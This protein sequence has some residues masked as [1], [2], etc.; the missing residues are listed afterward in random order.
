MKEC[1]NACNEQNRWENRR[2]VNPNANQCGSSGNGMMHSGCSTN[3]ENMGCQSRGQRMAGR[4]PHQQGSMRCGMEKKQSECAGNR[5]ND[6][7]TGAGKTSCE[8]PKGGC[9]CCK[10]KEMNPA[11]R[12]DI[13]PVDE[14]NPGMG[15]VPWQNFENLFDTCEGFQNGSIFKDLVFPFLGRP[16]HCERRMNRR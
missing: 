6:C 14:M 15:Y 10:E 9:G 7:H 3:R 11:C 5:Q 16:L 12:R 1:C 2:C 13:R 4:M 8:T